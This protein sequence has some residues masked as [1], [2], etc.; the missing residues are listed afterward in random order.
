[1]SDWTNKTYKDCFIRT[2]KFPWNLDRN[3]H[4]K[5]SNFC[6]FWQL[7]Q[8]EIIQRRLF[9]RIKKNN[10]SSRCRHKFLRTLMHVWVGTNWPARS[11][12]ASCL[13]IMLIRLLLILWNQLF[14]FIKRNLNLMK[15]T[16]RNHCT[17][18]W[19]RIIQKII[20]F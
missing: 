10:I 17:E 12:P 13:S 4:A 16:H 1:M 6:R 14:N 20:R 15:L 7:S 19:G 18:L 11:S 8:S 2:Y 3:I 5:S 9:K